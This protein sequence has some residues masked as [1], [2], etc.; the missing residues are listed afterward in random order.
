MAKKLVK[1][2]F[3]TPEKYESMLK[4]DEY[5]VYFVYN[6]I[7]DANGKEVPGP[8]GTI[9]K[10]NTRIGSACAKDIVFD[11]KLIVTVLQGETDEDSVFYTIDAGT[12]LT[13]FVEGLIKQTAAWDEKLYSDFVGDGTA[14]NPGIIYATIAQESAF[15]ANGDALGVVAEAINTR[16]ADSI[17]ADGVITS[18]LEE[19][20]VSNDKLGRIEELAE[21]LD[22]ETVEVLINAA[23]GIQEV[24]D[25]YYTKEE[26]EEALA[27]LSEREMLDALRLEEDLSALSELKQEL[28]GARTQFNTSD[29][30]RRDMQGR[31]RLGDM[32]L[33]VVAGLLLVVAYA[34]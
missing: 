8:Y 18:Y 19:N 23:A 16:I 15:D 17:S 6:T 33:Q 3:G 27:G 5:T 28:D 21:I 14:A 4:R 20:Y 12:S 24:L 25:A 1:Y 10:G 34:L 11:E 29:L 13:Q 7:I 2:A 30:K 32:L 9:Y 31:L 26:A 22:E